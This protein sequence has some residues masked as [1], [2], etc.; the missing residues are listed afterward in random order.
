MKPK[1]EQG[2]LQ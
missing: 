2:K 1:T